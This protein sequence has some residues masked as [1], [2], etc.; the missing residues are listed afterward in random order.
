MS[1]KTDPEWKDK[2]ITGYETWVYGYDPETK[3]QSA[4]WRCQGWQRLTKGNNRTGRQSNCQN[5]CRSTGIHVIYHP[6]C[7]RHTS[8]QND[9]QQVTERAESKSSP[10]VTIAYSSHPCTDKSDYSGVGSD[11]LGTAL[12][13]DV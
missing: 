9:Y 11:Q 6:T 2:I 3:H 4:E 12:T 13:G 5:G 1:H 10:T 7:D 8:V